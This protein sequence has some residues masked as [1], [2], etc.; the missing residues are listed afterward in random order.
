[1]TTSTDLIA[2][3]LSGITLRYL[4]EMTQSGFESRLLIP[5]PTASLGLR[6][7]SRLLEL[8]QSDAANSFLI[9]DPKEEKPNEGKQWMLANGLTTKRIGSFVVVTQPGQ[10]SR[11]QESVVGSGGAVKTSFN[12]E[13]PWITTSENSAFSFKNEFLPEVVRNWIEELE[14]GEPEAIRRTSV[15]EDD[16]WLIE[17]IIGGVVPAL[18]EIPGREVLL[19]ESILGK[20][21]P[22][23]NV[24]CGKLRERFLYHCGIPL[25][26]DEIENDCNSLL[27][28]T[29]GVRS[30]S[31]QIYRLLE[32]I[33]RNAVL[34][35]ASSLF[36]NTNE[37]ADLR[38]AID[39]FFDNLGSEP[40]RGK[41]LLSISACLS[42]LN[43]KHWNLLESNT[44]SALFDIKNQTVLDVNLTVS[45]TV[46]LTAPN[47]KATVTDLLDTTQL[48]VEWSIESL[49]F[50]PDNYTLEIKSGQRLLAEI[51][52]AET[53]GHSRINL[54]LQQYFANSSAKKT[55]ITAKL[56]EDSISGSRFKNNS[57]DIYILRE[58]RPCVVVVE[59]PF[60]VF[61]VSPNYVET[62][63]EPEGMELS[64]P[65]YIFCCD[66]RYNAA[67][68][69]TLDDEQ[70]E[71]VELS[72]LISRTPYPVD[73]GNNPSG[74]AFLEVEF[75]EQ[76]GA[77]LQFEAATG[78]RGELNI[79]EELLEKF[80]QGSK[81]KTIDIYSRFSG[82]NTLPYPSL[83]GITE[84][85][86]QRITLTRMMEADEGFTPLLLDFSKFPKSFQRHGMVL[87][88]EK[89][90]INAQIFENMAMSSEISKLIEN[91]KVSRKLLIEI[92][93]G[94]FGEEKTRLHP[95]CSRTPTYIH[96]IKEELQDIIQGYLGCYSA[97]IDFLR[98]Y[99][100]SWQETFV[101]TY[102]DC[103]VGISGSALSSTFFL[104]G[105]WHPLIV[106]Q[107]FYKQEILF[108][109]VGRW[110][111][112]G[113]STHH[114][115]TLL[116]D[117]GNF[118]QIH[119]LADHALHF[120]SCFVSRTSDPNWHVALHLD[121][122][123]DIDG[124]THSISSLLSLEVIAI[125]MG[126]ESLAKAYIKRYLDAHPQERRL[127]I[128]IRK[129]ISLQETY[130]ALEA[131]M[132]E[133]DSGYPTIFGRQLVGGIH[134]F[135]EDYDPLNEIDFVWREPAIYVYD[136]EDERKCL[137]E[138]NIDILI[139]APS[140]VLRKKD[141]NL[142]ESPPIPRGASQSAG[143]STGI[144]WLEAS[145]TGV[146]S[147]V[148]HEV[149][150]LAISTGH[151]TVDIHLAA[152]KNI[153]SLLPV[154]FYLVRSLEIPKNLEAS[155]VVIPGQNADPAGFIQYAEDSWS[156][157]TDSQKVLWEYN[158]D[159]QG[160]QAEYFILSE[161]PR[162]FRHALQSTSLSYEV[163][164]IIH[165]LSSIGIAVGAEALQT[166]AKSLGV[167]G[168]VG[169][170]RLLTDSLSNSNSPLMNGQSHA[171]LLLPVDSFDTLLGSSS[172]LIR[173]SA[174]KSDLLAIQI[175]TQD[176]SILI[177]AASVEC[178]F[179][180]KT[181]SESDVPAALT[182]AR[183]THDRLRL[184]IDGCSNTN[185]FIERLALAKLIRYGLQ[186][187]NKDSQ[188]EVIAQDRDRRILDA[189]LKGDVTY[190]APKYD[191]I[192]ISTEDGYESSGFS[193]QGDGL[194]IRLSTA[195]WPGINDDSTDL[196]QCRAKISDLFGELSIS[197]DAPP[198]KVVSADTNNI[199]SPET[200]DETGDNSAQ[201]EEVTTDTIS[202]KEGTL[203]TE[204]T[205]EEMNHLEAEHTKVW[206]ENKSSTHGVK[207]SVGSD[208]DSHP[209]K[210]F[211]FWPSNTSLNQLNVGIVGDLGTGKTQLTKALMLQMFR[212]RVGNRGSSPK[213]LIFDYKAD[214]QAEDFVA[215]MNATV[216][217]PKDIPLN[218]LA[219]PP[220]NTTVL[221]PAIE[222]ARF[223]FDTLKKIYSGLGP[224]QN[225]NLRSAI[226][227]AY[228]YATAAGRTAPTI[229]DVCN[230]YHEIVDGKPD[231]MLAIL[232]GMVDAQLFESDDSKIS[233]LEDLFSNTIVLDLHALG[234]DDNTKNILVAI[235]LNMYY[236]YMLN[237]EKKA[238]LNDLRFVD[239]TLVVDEADNIMKYNF[240]VLNSLLLQGRE[241][242]VGVW[243]ASQY[244][245][246][247][248]TKEI[249]Y[250]QPLL[251]WF[252]HKVP[253]ITTRELGDIGLTD[254]NAQTVSQ[255]K[256]QD[257]FQFLYKT[258]DVPGKFLQGTP[259]YQLV[260]KHD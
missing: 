166:G 221:D 175:K 43:P 113:S 38:D 188:N 198:S 6:I 120:E 195:A 74:N 148:S 213:F 153:A 111:E 15:Q 242:G 206:S 204:L 160:D 70:L 225:M 241:F 199:D 219:P 19:F 45:S 167:V 47:N 24:E 105:P 211:D 237:L 67:V 116:A 127:E 87:A 16:E 42:N 5:A 7:Q 21:D 62:E 208:V 31:T 54:E 28:G 49:D 103:I 145:Q 86:E 106:A 174:K 194:W 171:G 259:F 32:T 190:I 146:A 231:S 222:R 141:V 8:L 18:N 158:I 161:I 129:G 189:I 134:L 159:V 97:I 4:G 118:K 52:L 101:L 169:A 229:Y 63:D 14:K 179:R 140:R 149:D 240:P 186:L 26:P 78:V 33:S 35:N 155:W 200:H 44:L 254:V 201:N 17:L 252:I 40:R 250:K 89:A 36:A 12:E 69:L 57:V 180:R 258:F 226:K 56:I 104:I 207:F 109:A 50:E 61:E 156:S 92:Y 80:R 238:F 112:K 220:L 214:Y 181:F 108:N 114:L 136:A 107:R 90:A 72:E 48:D 147:T 233:T 22:L 20:F 227:S 123:I 230:E 232:S 157:P 133:P 172:K 182:Q 91:Y 53:S 234:Q 110:L 126:T 73:P 132:Y 85:N 79:E 10:L 135:V 11:V 2:N 98:S 154:H 125:P 88:E 228:G 102:L 41:L 236:E 115:A 184:L 203:P 218:F 77:Y 209:P 66:N 117:S 65:S 244:L 34:E 176:E 30:I 187:S 248:K 144:S 124:L 139:I 216:I 170:A 76:G 251:T 168:Q 217:A 13:W 255:V 210:S 185:G 202:T 142:S 163:S 121:S 197:N 131:L 249:D 93:N 150:V 58:S 138:N 162:G 247:F 196:K 212:A 215:A 82:E 177:S 64:E 151:R 235:F 29:Y 81:A 128:R 27:N 173:G 1:M 191:C 99:S 178:K 223:A 96:S 224:V 100:C 83:G 256:S 60:S 95:L 25:H 246:H 165:D 71:A 39:S 51:P 257:L 9:I 119:A 37:L 122:N 46:G 183:Q 164:E 55:R 192:L 59:D 239:S 260:E 253:N 130:W 94:R 243:L 23:A 245:S 3:T 143:I 68:H 84:K 75:E 205:E 137:N 152:L 193:A